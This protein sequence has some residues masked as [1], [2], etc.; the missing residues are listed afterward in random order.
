MIKRQKSAYAIESI[1]RALDILE[2]FQGGSEEFGVVDFQRSFKLTKSYLLKLLATLEKHDLIEADC[3]SKTY[4]LGVRALE[5]A[6]SCNE[7]N[8]LL[9][10]IRPVL[11]ALSRESGEA[12]CLALINDGKVCITDK[13]ESRHAVRVVYEVGTVLFGT[14]ATGKIHLVCTNADDLRWNLRLVAKNRYAVDR[15]ESDKGVVSIGAPILNHMGAVMG[16]ICIYGPVERFGYQRLSDELI[17][18]VTI[19]AQAVSGKRSAKKSAGSRNAKLSVKEKNTRNAS[20]RSISSP[21]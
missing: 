2:W 17:P 20:P 10:N 11:R 1:N 18:L 14:S 3:P 8:R 7:Q 6:R 4:R 15:E 12:S 9:H 13:V 21:T 5:L 19:A 16:A